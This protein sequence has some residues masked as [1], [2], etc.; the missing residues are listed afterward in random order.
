[1][2]SVPQALNVYSKDPGIMFFLAVRCE[3][4]IAAEILVF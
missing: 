1:M 3:V 2:K 4:E